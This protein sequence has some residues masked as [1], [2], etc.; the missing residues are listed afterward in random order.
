MFGYA[1]MFAGLAPLR[2]NQS[3]IRPVIALNKPPVEV[4]S[5]AAIV[6]ANRSRKK[7]DCGG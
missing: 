6:C 1:A 4:C 7:C 3:M 2:V 5:T